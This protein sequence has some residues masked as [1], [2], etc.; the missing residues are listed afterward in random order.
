MN[1]AAGSFTVTP[2]LQR[3]FATFAAAPPAGDAARG[4]L[5][6][7]LVGHLQA[8]GFSD[9]LRALGPKLADATVDLHA[10]VTAAFVPSAVRFHYVFTL[11]ELFAVAG[12]LLRMTPAAFGAHP[13]KAVRLW[14]HE[15]ERVYGDRL[16]DEPDAATF[17]RLRAAATKQHF[18]ALGL[19]SS[20]IHTVAPVAA[21]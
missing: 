5:S 19:V 7:L 3:H 9:A 16:M 15:C 4:M 11:R 13:V 17:A 10:A 1:P 8:P 20:A 18:E 6:A 12:G 21:Q 2:R 14:V